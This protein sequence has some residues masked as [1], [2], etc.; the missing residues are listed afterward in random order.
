[1]TVP[2]DEDTPGLAGERTDLAWSRSALAVLAAVGAV[3]KRLLETAGDVRAE[4]VVLALLAGGLVAWA[5]AV[6]HARTVA[7]TTMTGRMLADP[8]RLRWVATGTTAL[9]FGA[10][11]LALL[12]D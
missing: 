2:E 11:T 6:A 12:P 9:A 3:V 1:V 5:L 4:V 8:R 10:L 7:E